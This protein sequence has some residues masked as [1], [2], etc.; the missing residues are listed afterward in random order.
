MDCNSDSFLIFIY[1]MFKPYTL[2][3]FS[4]NSLLSDIFAT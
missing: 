3:S 2:R 1:D 4:A